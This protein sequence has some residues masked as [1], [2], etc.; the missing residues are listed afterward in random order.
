M[1]DVCVIT[2]G[3]SGMGLAAAGYMPKSKMIVIAGRTV[4]KLEKAAEKLRAEGFEVYTKAC[5]TSD[6]KSVKALAEYAASL[7]NVR[8]VINA[9]G[10]S[11]S[12]ADPEKLLRVN[13]LGTVYVNSEFRKVMASGSVILDISSN[14]AYALPSVII[15][16]RTYKLADT[17]EEKFLK[18]L[19][20][21]CRL[22]KD[23]YKQ[24][25]LAYALSKNFTVWYA[26]KCAF[27]YGGDGI[28]VLSLSPGLISTDMGCAESEE[29]AQ[30]LR[31]GAEKRMG[32]PEE[33]GYAIATAADERNGYLAGVDI[34]CDGGCTFGR[35]YNPQ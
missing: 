23:K 33:L 11:P 20:R 15:P 28:R 16:K 27:E 5:D 32:T 21:L 26:G 12:M 10:L 25:G 17:D 8:N 19:L 13:A 34:L 6:R 3:G 14:S 30:M 24:S 1:A 9:A 31:Y 29:G 7:G 2:G 18:K 4:T 22:P 35:K